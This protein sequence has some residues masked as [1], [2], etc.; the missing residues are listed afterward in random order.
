MKK[1]L[2]I[3]IIVLVVAIASDRLLKVYEKMEAAKEVEVLRR[4]NPVLTAKQYDDYA[5][6][7]QF[8]LAPYT[9]F[10]MKPNFKSDTVNINSLGLRGAE[11]KKKK[12]S[13]YR[14]VVIGGSA[15]FG[16]SVPGDEMTFCGLLEKDLKSKY[17]KDVEVINA[18]VPAF[19]SMQELILLE[20]KIIALEPDMVIIFDGFND[21]L[22]ILK[23]EKRPNYPWW[24]SE[25]ERI[26]YK[27][28]SKLFMEKRLKKYRPTKHILKWINKRKVRAKEKRYDISREQIAFYGRNLDL[29][30]HLAGS[31]GIKVVLVF[32]PVIMYKDPISSTERDIINSLEPNYLDA[33]EKMCGLARDAMRK[34]ARDNNVPFIDGTRFFDGS[35]ED[36]FIDEVHFNQRGNRIVASSLA[37]RISSE[38][39]GKK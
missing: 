14:I 27:S 22:T 33:L 1:F 3:V 39:S 7:T 35:K 36:I 6:A 9:V 12:E 24:F 18:G 28:I 21:C 19:I 11:I 34:V 10:G 38:K 32:Q 5:R 30:C 17:G 2:Y 16:G 8:R 15:V 37:D 31:Y 25:I 29:M 20:D 23:R 26:Y 4:V 13:C